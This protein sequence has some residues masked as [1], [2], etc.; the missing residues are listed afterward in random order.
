MVLNSFQK[1]V[2]H[3]LMLGDGHIHKKNE[4]HNSRF[5]QTFGQHSELFAKYVF[6]TFIAFCTTKGLY[7]Y[8]VQSGKNSPFYQ[9]FIVTTK[10]LE[11]LNEFAN[12]YYSVNSLGKRIKILP[13]EIEQILTPVVLA[14]FI[15]SDGNFHKT[16]QIIRLYTNNY[17]KIEVELLSTAIF[18][19]FGIE[20]R[21]EHDRKEQYILVIRKTQ[22]PQLQSLVKS[23]II[24][25]MLYR[26]GL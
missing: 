23:H 18:N 21:V 5:T 9:R 19:K 24:Q 1:Q 14:N 2:M 7:S 11:I 20:S 17:T 6:E 3:G 13:L 16:H 25:S 12:M 4:T 15:M 22:V 10:S 8:K 26:I